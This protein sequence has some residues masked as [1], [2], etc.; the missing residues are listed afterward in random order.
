[1]KLKTLFVAVLLLLTSAAIAQNA[2][3]NCGVLAVKGDDG[4]GQ[5]SIMTSVA[6]LPS[7]DIQQYLGCCMILNPNAG[8]APSAY[9]SASCDTAAY[10]LQFPI[11]VNLVTLW[12]RKNDVP[13]SPFETLVITTPDGKERRF[14][15]L[16]MGIGANQTNERSKEWNLSMTLPAGTTIFIDAYYSANTASTC[17]NTACIA[18]TVWRLQS[19]I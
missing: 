11:T 17:A 13:F 19:T 1:M 8:V 7:P 6:P 15:M 12:G 18:S 2:T 5:I 16:F 4:K 3:L 10:T 14:D 9:L